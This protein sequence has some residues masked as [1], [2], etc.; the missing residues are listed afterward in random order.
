MPS[1]IAFL[2]RDKRLFN[3]MSI[4]MRSHRVSR[5]RTLRY[6]KRTTKLSSSKFFALTSTFTI[7]RKFKLKNS[8]TASKTFPKNSIH[9]QKSINNVWHPFLNWKIK[10]KFFLINFKQVNWKTLNSLNKYKKFRINY[11]SH[12]VS[13]FTSRLQNVSPNFRTIPSMK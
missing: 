4:S 2:T 6:C 7:C 8:K 1:R 3:K 12:K 10:S 13:G 11:L 5:T 9:S